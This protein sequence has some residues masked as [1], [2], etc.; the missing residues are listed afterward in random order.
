MHLVLNTANVIIILDFRLVKNSPD[1]ILATKSQQGHIK[2]TP[3]N[4]T[5]IIKTGMSILI[6]PVG[7]KVIIKT[8]R[9]N[10]KFG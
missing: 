6:I 8:P 4:S 1:S 7:Y 2:D 3:I 5:Q 9:L 10:L